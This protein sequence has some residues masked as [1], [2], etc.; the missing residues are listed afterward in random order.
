AGV[1]AKFG[2]SPHQIPDFLALV[3]DTSDN[4][5]GVKGVGE[6]TAAKWLQRYGDLDRLKAQADEIPGKTGE[7]L[8]EALPQLDLYKAL[9]T[10]HCDVELPVEP[11]ALRYREP[12]SERLR[13]LFER[14]ELTCLL[15]RKLEI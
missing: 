1:E 4:I 14:L 13:A 11:Q 5:P 15:K 10:I 3:G 9:A 12:D 6:K 8:R 7:R 2:V